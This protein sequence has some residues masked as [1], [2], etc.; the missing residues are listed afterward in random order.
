MN[1]KDN[2]DVIQAFHRLTNAAEEYVNRSPRVKRIQEQ[3]S[4]LLDAIA[5]AQLILSVHQLPTE[6]SRELPSPK[7]K[8]RSILE[9]E[10]KAMRDRLKALNRNLLP[11]ST[12]L[13]ALQERA[14][15]AKTL[16]GSALDSI[17][18][19]DDANGGEKDKAA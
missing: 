18:A 13:E 9:S 5:N 7:D 15:K 11:V 4:A 19:Q 6:P 17:E 1:R 12:E 16:L 3:R 8:K 2:H 14:A 10:V